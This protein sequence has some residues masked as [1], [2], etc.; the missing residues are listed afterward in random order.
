[1]RFIGSKSKLLSKID[2]FVKENKC[3]GLVF[4]DLF[5]GTGCVGRYF[6]DRFNI[7]SNDLMYFSYIIQSALIEL[8]RIPEFKKLKLAGVVD[9]IQYL[10][11][12]ETNLSRTPFILE[13]YSPFG[14]CTRQYLTCKNAERIDFIRQTIDEWEES[15]L[16]SRL[17]YNYL[18]AVLIEAIPFV[19]NIAGTYGAF[20]KH[21]DKRSLKD[22]KLEHLAVGQNFGENHCYSSDG[23]TVLGQISGDILYLDPPYN[24]RQYVPNYHLLETVARYDYPAIT[25]KTGLRP[26]TNQRS[27]LCQKS[28]AYDYLDKVIETANFQHIVLSYSSEGIL[29]KDEIICILGSH[30]DPESINL[31]EIPY[32]RY[33]HKKNDNT[34]ELFEYLF[35][36]RKLK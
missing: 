9:P 20:L 26:Y 21:W 12:A 30:C 35:Y 18:L 28:K 22:I 11:E 7:I 32:R 3:D 8:D 34:P 6:K 31:E 19:S 13:N 36:A 5:S 1:M 4:C 23:L 25:G 24:S 27:A 2:S 33:K 15:H 29:S 17:E 16:I 14:S 10:S